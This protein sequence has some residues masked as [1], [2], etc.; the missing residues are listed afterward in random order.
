MLLGSRA[1]AEVC[2]VRMA[3]SLVAHGKM[4]AHKSII[5][6]EFTPF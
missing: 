2:G 5:D 1:G 3:G 6:K 4:G